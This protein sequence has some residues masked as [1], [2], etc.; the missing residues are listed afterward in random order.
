VGKTISIII[1]TVG[2]QSELD[3]C[4]RAIQESCRTGLYE[5]II[6]DDAADPP[7]GAVSE[8]MSHFNTKVIR[9]PSRRGAA[10]SRNLG[11]H[12]ACG[13]ILVFL[14]D[15]SRVSK[16][17]FGVVQQELTESRVAIT[18][19]VLGIDHSLVARARQ[20]RYNSRYAGRMDGEKVDFLAGGNCAIW[21]ADFQALGGFPL[22]DT[23]SDR[24]LAA[25][26]FAQVRSCHFIWALAI[27]HRNS[28]GAMNA[29]VQAF[30]AG[31]VSKK[32]PTATAPCGGSHRS[33]RI[34][35]S[36]VPVVNGVLKLAFTS[37][38]L[39]QGSRAKRRTD[40][41][42]SV[43]GPLEQRAR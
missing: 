29:L 36:L 8:T 27:G 17:W 10:E 41:V 9:N 28:K 31:M 38:I 26:L 20:E 13:D 32:L 12:A 18:G 30:K 21:R 25:R 35:P 1:P 5:V 23:M 39:W 37:G 40:P 16:N 15:D 6:V 4:L 2:R 11:A 7:I 34:M 24:L 33:L 22:V 42:E 19:P 14:D 3:G 43:R